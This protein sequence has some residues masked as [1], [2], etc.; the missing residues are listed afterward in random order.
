MLAVGTAGLL[1]RRDVWDRLGGLDPALPLFRDDI[2]FGWRAQ[3]A[4][5]RVVVVPTARVAD[6]QASAAR[7]AAGRRR[8]RRAAPGRPDPR[9][10][11]R[12]GRRA[13]LALPFLLVWFAVGGLLRAVG[14]LIAKQPR[15][16][17]DELVSVWAA[18]LTPWRVVTSRWR[19][20]GT[21][22]VPRRDIAQLL[23]PRRSA[24]RG[25]AEAFSGSMGRGRVEV[26]DAASP[27]TGPS[28]EEAENAERVAPG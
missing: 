21:R 1:V 6:A 16:A 28:A 11:G 12:D 5:H 27:E 8:A 17:Y 22:E 2:D 20:R 23:A 7:P 18:V 13:V 9:P 19:A 15:R 10:A 3:L 24:F 26:L 25:F 14:L 4:G